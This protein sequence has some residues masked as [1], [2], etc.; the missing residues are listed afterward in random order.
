MRAD[1]ADQ[2]KGGGAAAAALHLIALGERLKNSGG[3]RM[4]FRVDGDAS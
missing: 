2:N 1:P 4:G 3:K